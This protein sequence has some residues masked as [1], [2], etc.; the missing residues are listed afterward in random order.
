M[1]VL[2]VWLTHPTTIRYL[3]SR[4][5]CSL[6]AAE[7]LWDHCRHLDGAYIHADWHVPLPISSGVCGFCLNPL[8]LNISKNSC[9]AHLCGDYPWTKTDDGWLVL[10]VL[11]SLKWSI[12]P[13]DSSF[14][15]MFCKRLIIDLS[16]AFCVPTFFK[17]IPCCSMSECL[18]NN[19]QHSLHV[20]SKQYCWKWN[21][22]FPDKS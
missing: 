5:R 22:S 18:L 14:V 8:W 15:I 4:A 19:F 21:Q 2:L 13:E 12:I 7:L 1:R 6:D 9:N 16:P 20:L 11:Y 10:W 3:D 17:K